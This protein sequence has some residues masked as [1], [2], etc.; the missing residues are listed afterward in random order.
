[1]ADKLKADSTRVPVAN[2]MIMGEEA[3]SAANIKAK[4]LAR[5]IDNNFIVF[6]TRFLAL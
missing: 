4:L 3:V 2:I 5:V 1:M 6:N